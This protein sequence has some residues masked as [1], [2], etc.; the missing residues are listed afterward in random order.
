MIHHPTH[1]HPNVASATMLGVHLLLHCRPTGYHSFSTMLA[2]LGNSQQGNNQP[3]FGPAAREN[4]IIPGAAHGGCYRVKARFLPSL[5]LALSHTRLFS[6]FL[7]W[8][9]TCDLFSSLTSIQPVQQRFNQSSKEH[10]T[11]S[12]GPQRQL[13]AC[14]LLSLPPGFFHGPLSCLLNTTRAVEQPCLSL[15]PCLTFP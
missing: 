6:T 14:A 11:Y 1:I 2:A 4:E 10:F 8:R 9:R 13:S 12:G 5:T 7:P 15:P 3:L